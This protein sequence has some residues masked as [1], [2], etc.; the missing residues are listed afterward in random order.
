MRRQTRTGSSDMT[1]ESIYGNKPARST[2][3]ENIEEKRNDNRC[4]DWRGYRHITT[5]WM[6]QKKK[7]MGYRCTRNNSIANV[8]DTNA[9][10]RYLLRSV[11]I[12]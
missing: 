4:G 1:N 10:K 8:N 11:S 12:D 7:P 2:R 3:T 9:C 5:Y 6:D